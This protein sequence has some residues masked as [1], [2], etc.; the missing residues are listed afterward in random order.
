[1]EAHEAKADG[2][3]AEVGVAGL[4]GGVVVDVDHVIEHAH[5]SGD[6]G[7]E[8]V[9]VDSTIADVG[10]KVDGAEVAD[11]GFFCGG[12][13]ED[14][15][16]EVGGVDDADVLLG[17][18]EVG[19]VLEGDPG[20]ACLEEHGEHFAPEGLGF[21][22]F[23]E[24]DFAFVG[25]LLV[26]GIAGFEGGACEV[27]KVGAVGGVEEGPGAAGFDALHKE[28]GDPVGGVHVVGAA[29]FVTRVFAEFEEVFDVEMPGLE[30]CAHGAFAFAALVDGDSGVVGDFEEGD[31]ALGGAVGAGDVGACSADVGPVVAKAAGP[32]GE[33]GIVG[34]ALEDVVQIVH[35]G[36]KVAGGELWGEGAGVKERGG[37]GDEAVGGEEVVEF[38]GALVFLG[39]FVEGEAEGNAHP[40]VL[41]CLDAAAFDV[42]EV[43]V[44]DGLDAEVVEEEVSGGLEGVSDFLE[45]VFEEFGGEAF[46][47]D[48]AGDVVDEVGS[49]E[50]G[51]FCK[52]WGGIESEGF[53]VND[54]EHEAGGHVG[55]GGVALN[56]FTGS[57]DEGVFELVEAH[58]VVELLDGG[59]GDF[60]PVGL[61][62]EAF[63]GK[64]AGFA[65]GMGINR[66]ECAVGETHVELGLWA[67]VHS[68]VATQGASFATL[69]AVEDVGAC[70]GVVSLLHEDL[71]GV[72][73]DLLDFDDFTPHSSAEDA[74]DRGFGGLVHGCL[75]GLGQG[76]VFGDGKDGF[77]G[78]F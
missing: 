50:C 35:D 36:G 64:A 24:S 41:G 39:A 11:G 76:V 9:A 65:Q 56:T 78:V 52:C 67:T 54:V 16:A 43:T 18:A 44:V 70:Y 51:D 23:E 5:G 2:A 77:E 46:G 29:A 32:F 22:A 72:I 62:F 19:G 48:A 60:G 73:L 28:V 63:A 26:F 55:V 14:L 59:L 47:F 10:G 31:D 17:G 42:D 1:M 40:K 6:G 34:D 8:G 25:H 12:V 45:V 69:F 4:G 66:P 57:K 68:A 15:G 49:V 37:G 30:V 61:V 38:D 7:S 3:V 58:A 74:G 33:F 20:V 71:F 27:V 53:A 13:E 21:D 75:L